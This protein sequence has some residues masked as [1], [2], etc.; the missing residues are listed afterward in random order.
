MWWSAA[1][2]HRNPTPFE[3]RVHLHS[4][5]HHEPNGSPEWS[6]RRPSPAQSKTD[7]GQDRATRQ[8][9]AR[10]FRRDG[11]E[12]FQALSH[13]MDPAR[14]VQ[15]RPPYSAGTWRRGPRRK[16]LAA[17]SAGQTLRGRAERIT[18]EMPSPPNRGRP[19]HAGS[20]ANRNPER[21]DRCLYRL[22]GT[23]L[24]ALNARPFTRS[25]RSLFYEENLP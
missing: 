14:G 6:R 11:T 1:I 22:P 13:S 19:D 16:S 8:R 12:S 4:G 2:L 17:K 7:P 23:G 3:Q 20:S 10:C 21:L 9:P 25:W 15:D 5:H 18:N 24:S